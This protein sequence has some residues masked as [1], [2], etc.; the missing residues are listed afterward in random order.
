M[1]P[2]WF[3]LNRAAS[4]RAVRRIATLF[5]LSGLV[6]TGCGGGSKQTTT[7]MTSRADYIQV[8]DAICHN[9][10][11]RR[12]DLESQAQK[13]EPLTTAGKAHAVAGLLREE[14]RNLRTEAAELA[15]RQPPPAQ[16]GNLTSV[17]QGIRA[18][19]QA[20]NR[21][22]A[23]YDRLDEAEIRRGQSRVGRVAAAGES[24]ARRYGFT[25][26]GR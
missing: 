7:A 23:A 15:A 9:H 6:V 22:A 24:V 1:P 26:C 13:L 14:A 2:G 10:Q 3:P 17:L 8:A 11:S 20:V 19:A 16:R 5:L 18:R 21:W 25:T 4:F 12:D